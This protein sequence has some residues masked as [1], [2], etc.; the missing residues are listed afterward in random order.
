MATR[1]VSKVAKT[2]TKAK[3]PGLYA[4][5]GQDGFLAERALR[6][7]VEPLTARVG[8]EMVE[9]LDGGDCTW[10]RI[11]DIARSGSLFVTERVV[12]VRKCENVK[13]EEDSLVAFIQAPHPDV[14]LVLM[15]EKPDR[16]RT[17]WRRIDDAGEMILVEPL[18]GKA[19]RAY[20]ADELRRRKLKVGEDILIELIER[21]GQDLRRL[22]GEIDK[23]EAFLVDRPNA[24]VEELAS[25][26]GRSMGQPLYK[27]SDAYTARDRETVIVLMEEA[28]AAGEA[29]L[30]ILATFH[31]ATRQMAAARSLGRAT[32]TGFELAALLKVPAFKVGDVM[33]A[34]RAWKPAD[35]RTAYSALLRADRRIKTGAEPTTALSS[36]VVEILG[37]RD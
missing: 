21:F 17:V 26:L 22:V 1:D 27:L 10:A 33:A 19:L 6:G 11:I 30:R 31:R 23:L 16:R 5:V 14:H 28:L 4:I 37:K 13:G 2:K 24:S 25:V 18:K 15:A 34:A 32:G 7:I 8:P 29:P 9:T 12:V 20:V 35:V 36:V 3:I